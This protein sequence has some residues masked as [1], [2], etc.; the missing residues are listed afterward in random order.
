[1]KATKIITVILVL[2]TSNLYGQSIWVT[3]NLT[4]YPLALLTHKDSLRNLHEIRQGIAVIG[5]DT[6]NLNDSILIYFEKSDFYRDRIKTYLLYDPNL[7]RGLFITLDFYKDRLIEINMFTN[8]YYYLINF[9]MEVQ[10]HF[11]KGDF[12]YNVTSDSTVNYGQTI[13]TYGERFS[14]YHASG[15]NKKMTYELRQDLIKGIGYLILADKN[16]TKLI[17]SWCGICNNKKTW[18]KLDKYMMKNV[19]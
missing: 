17:P 19:R 11:K 13:V 12:G 6:I 8:R 2:V 10:R 9:K 4:N 15:S 7:Q 14:V 18:D 16:I 3:R 1:M 5:Q